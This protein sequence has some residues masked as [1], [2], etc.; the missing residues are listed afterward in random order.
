MTTQ[1]LSRTGTTETK[2]ERQL[3]R[4]RDIEAFEQRYDY[5]ASYMK[6]MLA[7]N[8]EAFETFNNFI[9]MASHRKHAPVDAFYVARIAAFQ[10]N[11]CGA[12]L[13]L[14]IRRARE[15]GV[16]VEIIRQ[17]L[18]GGAG[19]P[20]PLARVRRMVDAM[21]EN[22]PET[23]ELRTAICADFSEPAWVEMAVAIAAAAV[24]PTVKKALGFFL[25]CE[26]VR[27]D[28]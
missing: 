14:A 2:N 22:A 1:T 4:L 24:F 15:E 10:R 11:D 28:V 16:P 23:D 7:Q 27:L 19:L 21:A 9:P 26:R 25:G 5:D 12:C 20:E 3:A 8:P 18:D 13:Q 17:T 6:H